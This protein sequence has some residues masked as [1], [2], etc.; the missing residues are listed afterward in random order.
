MLLTER[1]SLQCKYY[2]I[3]YAFISFISICIIIMNQI[4]QKVICSNTQY[5]TSGSDRVRA[6]KRENWNY[7]VHKAIP[8]ICIDTMTP[9]KVYAS[10]KWSRNGDL[11][12]LL[13]SH[14]PLHATSNNFFLCNRVIVA[15]TIYFIIFMIKIVS[16][17][18]GSQPISN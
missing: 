7:H 12:H 3:L 14:W 11:Y 16:A 18:H 17:L 10:L 4:N 2:A 5:I 1:R 8:C 13:P 15:F 9:N 6:G